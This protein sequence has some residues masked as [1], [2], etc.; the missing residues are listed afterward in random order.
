MIF[1]MRLSPTHRPRRAI[2]YVVVHLVE[3]L[4]EVDV[5][6][7]A[8]SFGYDTSFADF[9]SAWWALRPA[10]EAVA[11]M[12]RRSGPGSGRAPAAIACCTRRSTTVGMPSW[13][14]P[15]PPGLGICTPLTGWG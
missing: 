1:S 4:F 6:D 10:T 13:R 5:H 9:S 8:A 15:F 2:R 14:V 11:V 3:K 12:S 7:D